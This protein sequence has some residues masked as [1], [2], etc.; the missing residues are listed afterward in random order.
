MALYSR[1]VWLGAQALSAPLPMTSTGQL[2]LAPLRSPCAR[3]DSRPHCDSQLRSG[4]FSDNL[5]HTFQAGQSVQIRLTSTD[6]DPYLIVH[7]PSGRQIDNDDI[8][9]STR[10]AGINIPRR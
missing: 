3:E 10:D 4:E 2:T 9:G 6:F 7:T 5:T 8:N 1:S